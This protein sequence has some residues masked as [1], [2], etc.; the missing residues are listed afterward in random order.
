[1]KEKKKEKYNSIL[2]RRWKRFRGLKRGYYSFLALCALYLLSFI[3]PLFVG[4]DALLVKYNGSYYFPVF[5]FYASETF[6]QKIFGEANYRIL[7]KT[8]SDSKTGNYVIMPLYPFG[9]NENLLDELQGAPPHPP[10]AVHILGTDDRGRDVFARLAY[11]FNI[12]ISFALLI[13]AVSFLIGIISGALLGYFGGKFDAFG[14]R[15]IEIWSTLP[16]LYIIMI[17][18]SVIAPGF[19]TLCFIMILFGWTG[20][21]YYVRAEV[22]REKGK[23][24]VLAAVSGGAPDRHIIFRHIIPNSLTSVISFA[25]FA[26]VANIMSLVALDF[27]GFGLQPPTPSWGEMISQGM[28]NLNYWWLTVFPLGT[29]FLTLLAVVFIGES[30]REAMDPREYYRIGGR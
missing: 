20:I 10:S 19:I 6:G 2:S 5:K 29:Q 7:K 3:L 12:S 1:M 4:R 13:T 24:Y 30:V 14:Q 11:G 21:T 28:G 17:L 8:F 9:P 27:L 22:Y 23:D 26:I 15:I 18:S 16:L 25:P